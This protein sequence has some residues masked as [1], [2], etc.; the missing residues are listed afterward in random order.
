MPTI[1]RN[2]PT[3]PAG[4]MNRPSEPPSMSLSRRMGSRVPSAVVVSASATGTKA[5]T[6]PAAASRPVTTIETRALTSQPAS[7]RR[8]DRSQKWSSSSSYPASRNKNPS[9]TLATSSIGPGA[10]HPATS[11]P[12]STPPTIRTT[13]WGTRNRASIAHTK[14]ATAETTDTTS[15]ARRPVSRSTTAPRS[16]DDEVSILAVSTSHRHPTVSRGMRGRVSVTEA[17]RPARALLSRR[18]K[19]TACPSWLCS[20]SASSCAS[21]AGGRCD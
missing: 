16:R 10:A 11:G 6:S 1:G 12:I 8:P 4:M 17:G 13:T 5:C 7:A 21:R 15:R 18:G 20:S 14:G 9:P 19:G 3:A 2:S